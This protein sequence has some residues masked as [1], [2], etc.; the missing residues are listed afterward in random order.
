MSPLR[1]LPIRPSAFAGAL[2]RGAIGKYATG[3]PH[4]SLTR[5]CAPT[6]LDVCGTATEAEEDLS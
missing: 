6:W 3:M 2:K 1:Q 4:L 5:R